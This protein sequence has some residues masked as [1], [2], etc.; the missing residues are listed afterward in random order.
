[1]MKGGMLES[2][3]KSEFVIGETDAD[4]GENHKAVLL[5]FGLACAGGFRGSHLLI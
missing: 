2:G 3:T 1:M 4:R 5:A